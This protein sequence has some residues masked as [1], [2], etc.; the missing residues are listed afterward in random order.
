M[1]RTLQEKITP[2]K[3]MAVLGL[4]PA[5]PKWAGMRIEI[6]TSEYKGTGEKPHAHLYPANHKSG[7]KDD[8]ITRFELTKK[9]PRK[10]KDIHSV[11]NNPA[12]PIDYLQPI[13][14][15]SRRTNKRGI[16]NWKFA[17]G[18]WD[19]IQASKAPG[20]IGQS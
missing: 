10:P 9:R 7:N 3:E 12:I 19:A 6:E 17:L 11:D 8:L 18:V 14:D 2:M 16:N 20:Q 15:W 1:K 5:T 13:F 4:V